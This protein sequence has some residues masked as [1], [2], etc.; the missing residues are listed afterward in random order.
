MSRVMLTIP[1]EFL[2]EIDHV[3]AAE[4]RNRSELF[5]EAMRQ[6]IKGNRPLSTP[7]VQEATGVIERLRTQAAMRANMAKDSTELLRA[8]RGYSDDKIINDD[9]SITR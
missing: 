9:E 4:H 6:Y 8:I 7:S 1:D 2:T 3:A 5:R